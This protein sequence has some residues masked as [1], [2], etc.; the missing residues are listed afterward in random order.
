MKTQFGRVG[1]EKHSEE[2]KIT[3]IYI[4]HKK[5][6]VFEEISKRNIQIYPIKL[7]KSS[8][9]WGLNPQIRQ[10]RVYE[11]FIEFVFFLLCIYDEKCWLKMVAEGQ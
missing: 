8:I 3:Q 6:S 5:S 11:I 7:S 1:E 2:K 10:A 4:N 9:F